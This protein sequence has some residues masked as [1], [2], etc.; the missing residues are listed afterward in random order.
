M[1]LYIGDFLP[2]AL[3]EDWASVERERLLALYLRAADKL[4]GVLIDRAQYDEGLEVCQKILARD[5]C[6]ER[7]YRLMMTAYSKQGNRPQALKR[8]SDV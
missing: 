8:I 3:Y 1:R 7:A 2:D 4:A 6:W 5:V